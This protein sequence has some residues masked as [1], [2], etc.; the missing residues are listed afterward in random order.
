[1]SDLT[2][3][4]E[5][6][7]KTFERLYT[8]AWADDTETLK[9]DVLESIPHLRKSYRFFLTGYKNLY[10]LVNDMLGIVPGYYKIY[11]YDDNYSFS[12]AE[13]IKIEKGEE[14]KLH[15]LMR[16]LLLNIRIVKCDASGN[17]ERQVWPEDCD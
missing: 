15:D 17:L 5:E 12:K 7:E 4:I 9:D 10:K 1:M 2:N 16:I 14:Y 6:S 13:I 11:Y 3:E 8:K